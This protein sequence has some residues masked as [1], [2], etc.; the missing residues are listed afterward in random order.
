MENLIQ[1]SE[2]SL[3]IEQE[4]VLRLLHLNLIYNPIQEKLLKDYLEATVKLNINMNLN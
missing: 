3:S 4:E 2:S 1:P